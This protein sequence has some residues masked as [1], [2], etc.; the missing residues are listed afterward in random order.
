MPGR[1]SQ[2]NPGGRH[3]D[4]GCKPLWEAAVNFNVQGD[5]N[6]WITSGIYA[7][8][9]GP[10]CT[11]GSIGDAMNSRLYTVVAQVWEF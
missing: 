7:V 8:G 3:K 2:A 4:A 6:V 11:I 10:G 9:A 1:K 5:G